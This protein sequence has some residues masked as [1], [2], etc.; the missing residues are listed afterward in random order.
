LFE[1]LLT[2]NRNAWA[3]PAVKVVAKRTRGV[4]AKTT[5][6]GTFKE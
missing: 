1:I 5:D 2:L 6:L 3:G 4:S